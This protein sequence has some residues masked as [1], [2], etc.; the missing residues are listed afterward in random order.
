[1]WF[2]STMK[3]V[4]EAFVERAAATVRL[5]VLQV[6]AAAARAGVADVNDAILR[7]EVCEFGPRPDIVQL[8]DAL[9]WLADKKLVTVRQAVDHFRVASLTV[10]GGDV[11]AGRVDMAG[12]L[13]PE[14]HVHD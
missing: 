1:M 8:N 12:V 11:G 9:D 4:G 7:S 14:Q 2:H 13:R 6:L 3:A 10:L 5:V